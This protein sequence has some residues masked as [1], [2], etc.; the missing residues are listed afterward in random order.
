MDLEG[1]TA[2]VTGAASGIGLALCLE[3]GR[4][5]CDV[6]FNYVHSGDQAAQL[7]GELA[8]LGRRAR[9]FRADVADAGAVEA[10]V[11]AVRED[12]GR[13]DYLVNNAGIVR[14]RLGVRMTEEDWDAV[15]DTNLKGAFHFCRA[16]IPGMLKARAGA[17]LNVT[18]VSGIAGTAGQANYAA[19]KAGLIGLT[20]AL[21]KELASRNITVN[22]LALG[23]IRTDMT[24]ALPEDYRARLL[25][26]IRGRADALRRE[27]PRDPRA[28]DRAHAAAPVR[29]PGGSCPHRRVPALR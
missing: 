7:E 3:L 25:E 22:A 8:A 23:L 5:G 4:R 19:A 18:S 10:M 1:R 15:L 16:V 12:F 29:H 2:G 6:A 20:K 26:A 11:A 14:D 24:A 13:I 21:A 9:A 17:I 28:R 27:A